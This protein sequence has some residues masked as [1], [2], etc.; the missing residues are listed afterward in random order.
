MPR[1]VLELMSWELEGLS[2]LRALELA[3]VG[4]YFPEFPRNFADFSLGS[5]RDSPR[6]TQQR[7]S[8]KWR[9]LNLS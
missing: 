7:T 4:Q 2:R 9:R 1:A 3:E 8:Q 5:P 6:R